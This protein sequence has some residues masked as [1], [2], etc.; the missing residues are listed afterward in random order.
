[1]LNSSSNFATLTMNYIYAICILVSM[2]FVV[3]L[4]AQLQVG[5]YSGAWSMAEL[6]AKEEVGKAY[7]QDKGLAAGL[8]RL[9]FHDCFVRVRP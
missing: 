2:G 9:H 7:F 8:M 5:F 1:M 3:H 4:E 6:F